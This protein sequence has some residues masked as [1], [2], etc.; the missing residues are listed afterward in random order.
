M[1]KERWTF[2]LQLGWQAGR[3]GHTQTEVAVPGWVFLGCTVWVVAAVTFSLA[4]LVHMRPARTESDYWRGIL[5]SYAGGIA[6]GLI[7]LAMMVFRPEW[8]N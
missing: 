1:P 7:A 3:D 2:K 6:I 8:F 4:L 5:M